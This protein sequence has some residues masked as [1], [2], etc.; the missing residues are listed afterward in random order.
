MR[1]NNFSQIWRRTMEE[2]FFGKRGL[3][4]IDENKEEN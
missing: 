3:G 2:D 4:C 1:E